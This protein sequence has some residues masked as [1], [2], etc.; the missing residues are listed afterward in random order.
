MEYDGT[1][2][3]VVINGSITGI[4]TGING[5]TTG[6]GAGAGF[7]AGFFFGFGF[8]F[9]S[10]AAIAPRQQHNNAVNKLEEILG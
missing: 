9:M 6:S 7:G 2:V 1:T 4:I 3:E 8:G 10:R 5:S